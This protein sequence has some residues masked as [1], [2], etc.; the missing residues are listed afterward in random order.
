M[1]HSG[2]SMSN[3]TMFST[4]HL[5][6]FF[7]FETFVELIKKL[8]YMYMLIFI[9]TGQAVSEIWM[10]FRSCTI[11]LVLLDIESCPIYLKVTDLLLKTTPRALKQP[12]ATSC[13][14]V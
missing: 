4:D 6:F 14:P 7:K 3:E 12:S 1:S 5:R 8:T 13:E 2:H 11:T 10:F 9:S